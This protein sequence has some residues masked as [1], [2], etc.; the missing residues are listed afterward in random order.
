MND[1]FVRN[2]STVIT[3]SINDAGSADEYDILINQTH[4]TTFTDD[5][6]ASIVIDPSGITT[7][8]LTLLENSGTLSFN[9]QL[10]SQPVTDVVIDFTSNDTGE[11]TVSSSSLTFTSSNWNVDQAMIL[12]AVND[13]IDRDDSATLTIS[14]NDA[15]SDDTYDSI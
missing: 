4:T 12:T 10:G 6:S 11:A 3:A 8:G 9:V 1:D 14:V 2:D 15:A 7:S 5:D 13:D